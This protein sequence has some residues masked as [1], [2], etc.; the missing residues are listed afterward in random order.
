MGAMRMR[1]SAVALET[2]SGVPSSSSI[3]SWTDAAGEK[4]AIGYLRRA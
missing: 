3:S 4:P 2:K 1:P